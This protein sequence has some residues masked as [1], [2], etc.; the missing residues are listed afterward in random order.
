M[1]TRRA[2]TTALAPPLSLIL[3]LGGAGTASA[4]TCGT[5]VWRMTITSVDIINGGD[6]D[7]GDLY[8]DLV[9]DDEHLW[10]R[11]RE[12]AVFVYN[13]ELPI[14]EGDRWKMWNERIVTPE[15]QT[16]K[17]FTVNASVWDAD[18]F[19]NPDDRVAVGVM[20]VDP[21]ALGEGPHQLDYCH[22]SGCGDGHTTIAYTLTVVGECTTE[23]CNR[24]THAAT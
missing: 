2:L 9:F 22:G 18:S 11:P 23:Q 13:G 3:S 24:G 5:Q 20:T 1:C 16:R 8:G 19:L 21:L 6:S 7:G 17:V 10:Q 12:D 14:E 4:D 15:S